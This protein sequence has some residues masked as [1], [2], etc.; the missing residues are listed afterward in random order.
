MDREER[1]FAEGVAGVKDDLVALAGGD[2]AE[3]QDCSGLGPCFRCEPWVS[4]L[5]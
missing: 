2:D 3:V 4:K 1:E 5:R